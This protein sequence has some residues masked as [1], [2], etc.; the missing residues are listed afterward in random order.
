M[1]LYSTTPPPT[2]G[3]PSHATKNTREDPHPGD[4]DSP[5]EICNVATVKV[6]GEGNRDYLPPPTTCSAISGDLLHFLRR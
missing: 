4:R 1:G 3:E 5:L 2:D 6:T